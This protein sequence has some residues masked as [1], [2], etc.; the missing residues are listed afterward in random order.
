MKK[1]KR[2][3]SNLSVRK[4]QSSLSQIDK[5]QKSI[6]ELNSPVKKKVNLA[7]TIKKIKELKK[8][9]DQ[10]DSV[11]ERNNSSLLTKKLE[12]K[13]TFRVVDQQQSIPPI[14]P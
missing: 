9:K 6:N 10:E 13:Q 8:A 14:N 12:K 5:K 3:Q 1:I 2:L 7:Q 11:S 4:S